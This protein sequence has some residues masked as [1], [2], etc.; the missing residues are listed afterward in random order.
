MRQTPPH[1]AGLPLGAEH[2]HTVISAC[3][4][5]GDAIMQLYHRVESGA[6]LSV[7]YKQDASPVTRADEISNDILTSSLSAVFDPEVFGEVPIISE[8]QQA[9]AVLVRR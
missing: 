3:E 1:D 8:E 4:R 7:T 5:A 9:P 6:A 2:I